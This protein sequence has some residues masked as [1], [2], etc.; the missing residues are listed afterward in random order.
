MEEEYLDLKHYLDVLRRGWWLLLLGPLLGAALALGFNFSMGGAASENTE[1]PVYKA[2]ALVLMESREGMGNSPK[3]IEIRPVLQDAVYKTGL[4]LSVADLRAKVTAS[5]IVGT[6]LM[7]ISAEDSDRDR[8]ISI[9]N[10]VSESLVEYAAT[11]RQAQAD[12]PSQELRQQLPDL[13]YLLSGAGSTGS[14]YRPMVVAPAEAVQQPAVSAANSALR[15]VLLA[16]FVGALTSV[17]AAI[18]MEHFRQPVSSPEQLESRCGLTPLGRVPRWRH[19]GKDDF[20]L[21][22]NGKFNPAVGEAVRKVA[23]NLEFA[24]LPQEARTLL[25]V[26]PDTGDG[27]SALLA[28]LGV[29]LAD[30][31]KEVVLVDADLRFP[32][33]HRLFGLDN[34]A[35]LT[36]LLG[37]PNMAVAD[38]LQGTCHKRLKVLTS[39]PVPLNPLELLRCPRMTWLLEQLKETADIVLLDSPPAL[40]VTDAMTLAAQVDGAVLVIDA[41]DSRW[42][43]VRAM[44]DG[45]QKAGTPMMGYIWNRAAVSPWNFLAPWQR[46]YRK[47][48]CRRY[49]PSASENREGVVRASQESENTRRSLASSQ[50]L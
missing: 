48:G 35:G 44:L 9:A 14:V 2:T 25:V 40:A 4:P 21:A 3:L 43:E 12:T 20:Q 13:A 36:S 31:W 23:T 27:R 17:G 37:D 41:E 1:A 39:G 7:E 32:S 30:V 18:I 19:H 45:L 29:A 38:V 8:A 46:Y 16:A 11:L 5:P 15:N 50:R 49:A 34:Q 33:L 28:N 26:S 6:N 22:L 24:V 47:L 42:D 10:A